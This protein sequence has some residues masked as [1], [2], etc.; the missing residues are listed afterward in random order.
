[1]RHGSLAKPAEAGIA[2]SPEVFRASRVLL[3]SALLGLWVLISVELHVEIK[4]SGCDTL[5]RRKNGGN[6]MSSS[7]RHLIRYDRCRIQALG[8]S[9]LSWRRS[10]ARGPSRTASWPATLTDGVIATAWPWPCAGRYRQSPP[11]RAGCRRCTGGVRGAAHKKCRFGLTNSDVSVD[12]R[13]TA[14]MTGIGVKGG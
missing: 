14:R 3:R 11:P 9:G 7:Y 12:D 13:E 5:H 10:V 6:R 4:P 2:K 1:M 8:K